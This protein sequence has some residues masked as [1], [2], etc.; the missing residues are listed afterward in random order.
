MHNILFFVSLIYMQIVCQVFK[1]DVEMFS[2]WHRIAKKNFYE[3]DI[4]N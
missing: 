2:Y 4:D 3:N 1:T